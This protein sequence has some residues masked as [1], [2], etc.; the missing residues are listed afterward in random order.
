MTDVGNPDVINQSS[1]LV[2][3]ISLLISDSADHILDISFPLRAKVSV[4]M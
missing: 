4:P 2:I 3:L 1:L